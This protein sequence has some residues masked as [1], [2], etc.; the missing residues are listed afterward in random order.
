VPVPVPDPPP[1][2]TEFWLQDMYLSNPIPLPVN[3][4]PF[5]LFPR[6]R[7]ATSN[8]MLMFAT[9]IIQFSVD[10]KFRIDQ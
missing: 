3:S 6:Q 7:F 2:A 10:F 5:F 4:N 1:Q 8:E 9:R